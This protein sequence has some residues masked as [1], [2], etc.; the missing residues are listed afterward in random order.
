MTTVFLTEKQCF[1]CESKN[2]YPVVDLTLS[3]VGPRDLDG[4]PA[5]I[6]RSSVYLWVQRCIVCGYCAPEITEGQAEDRERVKKPEYV[7][8]LSDPRYPDTANAFL[9]H[10]M[11]MKEGGLFADAGWAAVFAAWICDDNGY[12]E[13]AVV[14]RGLAI[15]LFKEGKAC[16]QDFGETPDVE[17]VYLIDLH[18]RRG[19]FEA[20]AA[21]CDAEFEKEHTEAILDKL[22]F[23]RELIEKRDIAC[24]N[25]TEAEENEL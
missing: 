7:T 20:A 1:V 12:H 23:E 15:E 21:I 5:H 10:S 16:G 8:Q 13:S 11:L 4:R 19:E 17:Q 6:Q 24:H 3:I 2:R 22:Y 25:D 18:R 14:C 9:C